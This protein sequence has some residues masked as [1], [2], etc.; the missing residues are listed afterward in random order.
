MTRTRRRVCGFPAPRPQFAW[1]TPGRPLASTRPVRLPLPCRPHQKVLCDAPRR[2][3]AG[4][5]S[6]YTRREAS[7]P[8]ASAALPAGRVLRSRTAGEVLPRS[9]AQ[10]A[11]SGSGEEPRA[12]R[13]RRRIGA[14]H[15]LR[16]HPS[17]RLH[18]G[19]QHLAVADGD[20]RKPRGGGR[21]GPRQG[22]GR[23]AAQGAH[24]HRRPAAAPLAVRDGPGPRRDRGRRRHR[25]P[26]LRLR[27]RRGG[28][29]DPRRRR[30]GRRHRGG[31]RVRRHR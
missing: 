9:T 13:R 27:P 6:T 26:A 17:V 21:G 25:P 4:S 19:D 11:P 7:G 2:L 10:V 24:G 8:T 16:A 12:V 23:V 31:R 3:P 29:A 1:S 22:A 30:C 15:A 5:D 20:L 18:L 28:R 14:H